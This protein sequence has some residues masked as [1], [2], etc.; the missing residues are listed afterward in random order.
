MFH[1]HLRSKQQPAGDLEVAEEPK[2]DDAAKQQR[3]NL[4]I[5]YRLIKMPVVEAPVNAKAA[6]TKVD[7][8]ALQQVPPLP[9]ALKQ[10]K[11]LLEER[12]KPLEILQNIFIADS[13]YLIVVPQ[14]AVQTIQLIAESEPLAVHLQVYP[15]ADNGA[16]MTPVNLR[17]T[18]LNQVTQAIYSREYLT[19]AEATKK[20]A[21]HLQMVPR[22]NDLSK[23]QFTQFC[24]LQAGEVVGKQEK[25]QEKKG[26]EPVGPL[27]LDPEQALTQFIG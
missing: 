26:A 5:N 4:N 16:T 20:R 18:V 7:K 10:I 24:K 13:A 25:K 8:S 19:A 22:S 14:I 1:F 11:P 27:S 3:D 12:S 21:G 6:P 23:F 2:D 9:E 17:E 15:L